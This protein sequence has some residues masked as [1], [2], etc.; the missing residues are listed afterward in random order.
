ML[1]HAWWNETKQDV[2]Y[3]SWIQLVF[4][5][6]IVIPA[7]LNP[8]HMQ[9]KASDL[10]NSAIWV[11]II[12]TPLYLFDGKCNPSVW[13]VKL[14]IAGRIDVIR[15][16]ER[17]GVCGQRGGGLGGCGLLL[18]IIKRLFPSWG[19]SARTLH[20]AFLICFHLNLFLAWDTWK[21]SYPRPSISHG[22]RKGFL[23][24]FLQFRWKY[25]PI[26]LK[27]CATLNTSST[28]THLRR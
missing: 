10:G 5:I 13:W 28:I 18:C 2:K 15:D 8:C 27:K 25:S 11:C 20:T 7:S 9:G 26:T 16:E 4:F 21:R 1:V 17:G 19:F 3:H 22:W 14:P 24:N 12:N 23:F 6:I